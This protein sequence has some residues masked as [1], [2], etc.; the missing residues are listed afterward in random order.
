MKTKKRSGQAKRRSAP[1]VEDMSARKG[2]SAKGG[3]TF[4]QA[5]VAGAMAG[6][7]GGRDS[8]IP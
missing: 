4:A 5:A 8:L 7:Q 3:T 1:K 2:R 6:A